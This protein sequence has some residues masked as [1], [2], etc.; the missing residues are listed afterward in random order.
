MLVSYVI[1]HAE[2]KNLFV[3]RHIFSLDQFYKFFNFSFCNSNTIMVRNGYK[4]RIYLKESHPK[5]FLL[6]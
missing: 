5:V 2:F 3:T 6:I 4:F 1:F